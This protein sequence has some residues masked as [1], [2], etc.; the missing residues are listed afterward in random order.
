MKPI[1]SILVLAIL[2]APGLAGAQGYYGGGYGPPPLPGGFHNR[3]GRLAWGFSVGLGYMNDNGSAVTCSG[4]DSQPL[5]GE[6][7][8]HLGGFISPRMAILFELQANAQQIA[9]DPT[10]DVTLV[11]TLAMGAIQFWL[12][13]QLWIK[14]GIGIAH[15]E[16]DDNVN[17]V[18]YE[19]PGNGLG[20][21][22]AVGFE[23]MSGRRFALDLQGRISE[24]TYNSTDDRITSGTV[25]IGLN[26]Y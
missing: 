24:G 26:W 23:I 1:K 11:Q 25:G 22:G 19:P 18:A 5:T 15:L 4:C 8:F 21:L 16:A 7:D 12:T 10:D 13:P 9:L 3:M 14:G 2:L 20:L 6:F 17:G